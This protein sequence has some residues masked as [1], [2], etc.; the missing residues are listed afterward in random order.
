MFRAKFGR[1]HWV[2]ESNL[3]AHLRAPSHGVPSLDPQEETARI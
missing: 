1:W 3:V 2:A